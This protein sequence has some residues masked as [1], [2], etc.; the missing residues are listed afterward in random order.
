[1]IQAEKNTSQFLHVR[2][3]LRDVAHCPHDGAES[4]FP[5]GLNHRLFPSKLL[6]L[7]ALEISILLGKDWIQQ[8]QTQSPLGYSPSESRRSLS[9]PPCVEANR[10][11]VLLRISRL[12]ISAR[13]LFPHIKSYNYMYFNGKLIC[14]FEAI[15]TLLCDG[16][17][18]HH[19]S[20]LSLDTVFLPVTLAAGSQPRQDSPG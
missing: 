16:L 2:T 13:I 17:G 7:S 5:G 15:N 19:T 12:E 3:K 11:F 20:L 18:N 9:F 10:S 1:M 6:R 14:D 4:E 8:R